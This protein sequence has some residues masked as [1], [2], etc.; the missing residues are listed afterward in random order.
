MRPWCRV[1]AFDRFEPRVTAL[2][3]PQSRIEEAQHRCAQDPL[4][5]SF[6]RARAREESHGEVGLVVSRTR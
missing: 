3:V 6:A 5:L 4:Y 1:G 2:A